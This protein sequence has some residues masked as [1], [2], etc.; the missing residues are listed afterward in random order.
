MLAWGP[1]AGI[2]PASLPPEKHGRCFPGAAGV[3][4]KLG[5]PGA[6]SSWYQPL[7]LRLHLAEA[8][9]TSRTAVTSSPSLHPKNVGAHAM[10]DIH[11]QA[12]T[13]LAAFRVRCKVAG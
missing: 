9:T 4:A 2:E 1:Q 8:I 11:M 7:G 6:P 12:V 13:I 5:W 10:R 3:G